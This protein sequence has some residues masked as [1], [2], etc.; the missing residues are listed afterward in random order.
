[1]RTLKNTIATAVLFIIAFALSAGAQQKPNAPTRVIEDPDRVFVVVEKSPTFPG[2]TK[3]LGTYLSKNI[4]YPAVDRNNNIQGKVIVSFVVEPDG[5]L[6]DVNALRGP[7]ATLK[8]EAV[9]IIKLSP[10]WIAGAQGG[11]RVRVKYAVPV[12]FTLRS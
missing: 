10:K 1:M 3:A 4:K 7:S 9:R 8:A 2:G 11:K 5:R 12:N 6:T